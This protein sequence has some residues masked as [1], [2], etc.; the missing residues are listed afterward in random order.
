[1]EPMRE[2]CAALDVHKKMLIACAIN[3]SERQTRRFGTVYGELVRL[4]DWLEERGVKEVAMESTGVY[5]KAPWNVLEGRGFELTLANARDVKAV[6]GRKTDIKDAEWLAELH[7]HG[8]MK[9]SFVPDRG[10]RELRELVRHRKRLIEERGEVAKRLQQVLEG[11]NLKLGSVASNVLGVS[12]RAMLEQI[13]VGID[14][15]QELA[16]L[17]RARLRK[18]RAELTQALTGTIEKHQRLMLASLLPQI[19][20]LEAELKTLAEDVQART[21]GKFRAAIELI[22]Q[23]PG[24]GERAAE[25]ILAELGINMA[26]FPSAEACAS[27]AKICP[28]THQSADRWKRVG[29]GKGNVWLRSALVEAAKSASNQHNCYFA[30]LYRRIKARAGTSKATVAVAHAILVTIY[31]MLDRGSAYQDL[32]ANHFDNEREQ[33]KRNAVRRLEKLGF[34]VTIEDSPPPSLEEPAIA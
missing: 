5:W 10:H 16:G 2:R 3:S 34:K 19:D 26:Q 23:I 11:A 15:P 29:T 20:F 31:H 14:D 28:G 33:I 18:K 9:P 4:A 25:H 13:I 32:G 12:G 22:D 7:Q 6:P 21:A 27:W 30:A 24:I 8:L 17:A 1:M